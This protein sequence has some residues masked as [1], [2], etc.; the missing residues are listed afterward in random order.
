VKGA[1]EVKESG[2][3]DGWKKEK[4]K[5]PGIPTES[6]GTVTKRRKAR[7][8]KS[9]DKADPSPVRKRGFPSTPLRAGGM[10]MRGV[11]SRCWFGGPP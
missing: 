1:N 8:Y 2:I 7:R 11:W 4:P 10:T 3:V 5:M 6:V 9:E